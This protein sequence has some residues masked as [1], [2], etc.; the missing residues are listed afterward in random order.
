MIFSFLFKKENVGAQPNTKATGGC[1]T[2]SSGIEQ[3]QSH[4]EQKPTRPRK[5]KKFIF[6]NK[7]LQIISNLFLFV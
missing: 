1:E 3:P 5:N 2:M 6:K 7:R 4:S